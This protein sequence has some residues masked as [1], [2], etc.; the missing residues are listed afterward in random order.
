[1]NLTP[2]SGPGR[3]RTHGRTSGASLGRVIEDVGEIRLRSLY[4]SFSVDF[5]HSFLVD[6]ESLFDFFTLILLIR[7]LLLN[8]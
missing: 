6:P 1:M 2:N 5:T 7:F 3:G 8:K 4:L